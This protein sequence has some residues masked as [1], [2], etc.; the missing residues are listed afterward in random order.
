MNA[1]DRLLVAI[2]G[3]VARPKEFRKDDPEPCEDCC[4]GTWNEDGT[5]SCNSDY[6]GCREWGDWKAAQTG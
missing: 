2:F 1:A 4:L 3:E 5:Y 6:G